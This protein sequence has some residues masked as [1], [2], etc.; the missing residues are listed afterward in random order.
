M[1]DD[2]A[3]DASE[4]EWN[5]KSG[6]TT[7]IPTVYIYILE[8]QHSRGR[9]AEYSR[10]FPVPSSSPFPRHEI[11]YLVT[12]QASTARLTFE[13]LLTLQIHF[14]YFHLAISI[15]GERISP[16]Q[17]V[18]RVAAATAVDWGSLVRE[19]ARGIGC[20]LKQNLLPDKV[21]IFSTHLCPCIKASLSILWFSLAG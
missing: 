9:S 13:S 20:S 21:R 14:S 4:R 1:R 11:S 7:R 5:R 6:S 19:E 10:R 18:R 17:T 3:I 12:I 15:D 8:P 16:D 2:S